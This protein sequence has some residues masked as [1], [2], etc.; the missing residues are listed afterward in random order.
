MAGN[1]KGITIEIGGDTQPLQNALKGVNKQ[2]AESTKELKQI[3]KALKFDT[4]NVT[5]LTQKQEVLAKQVETTKEKLATLR[6][7]QAQVEAQFKSGNIGAEQYRAFQREVETTQ[8]VLKSYE[9]KLEGVNQALSE[10]GNRIGTT[11]SQWDS[12]KQEQA[13][14]ASESEKLTSQFKLQESELSSNASESEK[15]ALAQKKVNESSSL[16]EK[17][18]QNLE[19]QLELTKSQYGENSIEA[20]KLEQTLNDT[21]TAYNH[22]QNE[23]EEMSTSSTSAKDNL[24]EIN[25]LLKADILMEFSDRLAELSQKLIDFGKQSL[26]AFNEVDEGMDIIVTK[27]GAS[28]QAL[29]EMTTIAKNL[30]TEIPT[31]FNTAGSAVGELNTQFGLTG[32]S[33]KSASSYLIQFAS[34][35]GSDVT[36]S[37]ISAKKAIEAYGLQAT[38]LSSVLDSVTFTSQAT[39]VGVQDLMDKV[40][41]GAP[42][43]K[44]LGLSFDEGVALMGK[45]EKAGVDSSA[46]LSSLS[47]ASVKYAASGKTLQQGLSETIE[48]IK[49]STS[50]TEKLTLAS[51]IFGTKGAP[52]MVD[53]INR[54]ALSFDDLA[55]TAKKASG[56]V[57]STYEATLDPIDKFT[58]AQNE[59]KLA[60]AEVG[61]AI[62]VT[63]APILEILADL[64]RSVAEWF[65]SLSTPV[66]QFIVIVGALIAGLGLLL[67]IFLALQAA[68]LAMGVTIGGL[69]ASVAPIIAIVLGIVAVLALLIV[70]IK[71]LWEHNEGF[72]TAVMDIWNAIYSFIFTIIQEIS[73]FILSI[74]G[75]LTSWWTEN[76]ELI[77]AA[78]TTVW[79]AISTVI[80]TVMSILE[81]YIQ[82]AW[83]NIK[84]IIS[85]AWE[86]IKQV[87][88]TA[89]NLVL[90]IIKAIMQVITGD[91]SGAWETIKAVISTVWESIKS[92]V[93]LVLNTISQLISN[94]W[95]GIKNTISN[96]LSAI[97]NVVSTIWNSISS[98]ISGILNGI[99]STVSNVWNGVKNT[100]SN[101]I[102][103]AKNA[104]STAIT[105]IKNLF[106][107][108]FQW[109]HIPLPHFSVSGSANPLD[110]LK[111]Q[112]PRIGIE[113]YAKGGIL[114]KPTAFGTIGNSLMVGGEAGNEAVLP[115]NESTLGA[116]GRGIARTMDLRMPDINI[117]ITGNIIREQA[118]IEKIANEVASRIAE[119]LARQKQLRGATI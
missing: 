48:K 38:D 55:E 37:A 96:L 11:K 39:G 7:A 113:W 49:N 17:Q 109:P 114:T 5:L 51:D 3:D 4:G 82:A 80:T 50:E 45:F 1:I 88:E 69:I 62:A 100:I 43:I 74:W 26:E 60:L 19:K 93:S 23:M 110:W 24:S 52:R 91:W 25:H 75:T 84:L 118:D 33:L 29:E 73:D 59:A 57:G 13:R 87:V 8:T 27:T 16:L 6:Q 115:L 83:E 21:K 68:A 76:Q 102:N 28:G 86:I 9:S 63:F 79:N 64:L 2:A 20:N 97:S 119:E 35:N 77:L 104:V 40:V 90:G 41:S 15:L 34:I 111:G 46:S 94:T 116:I 72:R 54:G 14:L 66:K 101:A 61:D 44:A 22:L 112:I 71:E 10:N 92:I 95:N 98:T 12:L 56:T 67:P 89:I 106:N 108:R 58:T 78:A 65:S 117:S 47:K 32:D 85:T 107:F 30:A 42:Q 36:S 105:A 18:I 103:T 53:A 70:G 31:D 99:S 81:P